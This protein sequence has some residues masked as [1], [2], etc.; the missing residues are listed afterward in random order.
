MILGIV[1]KEEHVKVHALALE[2]DGHTVR[3]LGADPIDFPPNLDVM[4]LRHLSSSHQGLERA[5]AYAKARRIPT[6]AENGLTGM[7]MALMA[8]QPKHQKNWTMV[9]TTQKP[10]TVSDIIIDEDGSLVDALTSGKPTSFAK[11]LTAQFANKPALFIRRCFLAL[12]AKSNIHPPVES[13]RL[14]WL[15]VFDDAS[16]HATQ[17]RWVYEAGVSIS[18]LDAATRQDIIRSFMAKDRNPIGVSSYYPNPVPR[19]LANLVGRGRAYI[20]FYMW[21]LLDEKPMRTSMAMYAYKELSG[22]SQI[23]PKGLFALR[24]LFGFEWSLVRDLQVAPEIAKTPT[25]QVPTVIESPVGANRTSDILQQVPTVIE[26]PVGA[27]RTSDILQTVQDEILTIAI[28]MEESEKM[29]HRIDNLGFTVASANGAMSSLEYRVLQI[30]QNSEGDT[31]QR[32]D[33]EQDLHNR[34]EQAKK[35]FLELVVLTRG[36][37]DSVNVVQA[38]VANLSNQVHDL[39]AQIALAPQMAMPTVIRTAALEDSLRFLNDLGASVTIT[40]RG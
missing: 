3:L 19:V 15:S 34:F 28:R 1:S 5:R 35:D 12:D 2:K 36:L 27:N 24:D 40:L 6:V 11:Q 32:H 31:R 16:F 20:S 8:M 30:E 29:A 25:S 21:L 22:G 39:S 18:K 37:A 4:L 33:A 13:F 26:S 17:M 9:P 23:D 7:R 14:L 10:V 38:Q